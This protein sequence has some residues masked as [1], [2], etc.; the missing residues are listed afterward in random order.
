[1]DENSQG[2]YGEAMKKFKVDN[3]CLYVLLFQC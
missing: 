1:M 2:Y 3:A